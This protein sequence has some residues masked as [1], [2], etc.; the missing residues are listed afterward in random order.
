MRHT[1]TTTKNGVRE[2]VSGV[3]YK[4]LCPNIMC[5]TKTITSHIQWGCTSQM[6]SWSGS[7]LS[8]WQK[9]YLFP[10]ASLWILCIVIICSTQESCLWSVW[11]GGSEEW[12]SSREWGDWGM[13]PGLHFPW[14][15]WQGV[16][17]LLRWWQSLPRWLSSLEYQLQFSCLSIWLCLLFFSTIIFDEP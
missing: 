6:N 3:W 4:V 16:P 7:F 10:V 9:H 2:S 17:G 8:K 12:S 11:R 15:P 14:E 1:H 13:D 5:L